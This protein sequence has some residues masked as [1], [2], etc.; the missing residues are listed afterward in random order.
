MFSYPY[1][2]ENGAGE[3]LTFSHR[4]KESDGER[5][6]GEAQVAPG[7]GPPMHVHYLQE[8]AFTVVQGRLGF[9]LAGQEPRFASAGDTV[10]FRAG[11][12]HR[13]W[14]AGED[15]LRCTAYVKPAGNVEYF[16]GALFASQKSNGGRRP[17]LFDIAFLTLR[18]RS[19][20]RMTA[21]PATIQRFAFPVLFAIGSALGKYAKY[22]DAPKPLQR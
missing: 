6:V 15:E 7:A 8:E 10:A 14:N 21:I 3:R 16:L 22:A 20:Y 19:E 5:V 4:V 12:P 1:T 13:F 11:E 9:Q 18:Y 17:S 2:I